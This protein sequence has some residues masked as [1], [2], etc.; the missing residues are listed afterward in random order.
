MSDQPPRQPP[1][2]LP[3]ATIAQ[4]RQIRRP[5][6]AIGRL[7]KKDRTPSLRA[8]KQAITPALRAKRSYRVKTHDLAGPSYTS[9]T[10]FYITYEPVFMFFQYG[11][12]VAC[13]FLF[14]LAFLSVDSS[15]CCSH[16][17][18]FVFPPSHCGYYL[19]KAYFDSLS[20]SFV[21]DLPIFS[22]SAS[23]I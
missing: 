20:F 12:F 21:V 13:F 5:V 22:H 9:E 10:D 7:R 3:Q 1:R 19:G 4:P 23:L 15:S 11:P 14:C 17:R 6:S 18:R 2:V 16:L 8:S